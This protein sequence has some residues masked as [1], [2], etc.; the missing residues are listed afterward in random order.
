MRSRTPSPQQH[1]QVAFNYKSEEVTMKDAELKHEI[2]QQQ[3][4]S[5]VQLYPQLASALTR[6]ICTNVV[7]EMSTLKQ[8]LLKPPITSSHAE[9]SDYIHSL[10]M[11]N[12]FGSGVGPIA[13]MN[14]SPSPIMD[15]KPLKSSLDDSNHTPLNLCMKTALAGGV[16]V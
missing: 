2:P 16:V 14:S 10:I 9:T 1:Q 15:K 8:S 6:P 12:D 7:P 13:P 11:R 3:N 5:P 4:K